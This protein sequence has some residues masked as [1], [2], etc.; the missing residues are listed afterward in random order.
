[1]AEIVSFQKKV[2]TVRDL[3]ERMKPQLALALPKHLSADRMVRVVMTEVLRNPK[4][5]DCD[6]RSFAGA[7]IQSAQL[8][9]EIGVLGLAFLVP[10]RNTKADRLDCQLIPGYK[11]LLQ[12]ARRSGQIATIDPVIV[13]AKDKYRVVKGTS[14]KIEHI[15]W[16]KDDPGEAVA[17]YAIGH[18]KAGG[19]QF[20]AMWKRE[21]EEHAKRY[22]RAYGEGPW[23]TDFDAMGLKTVLRKLTKFLPMSIELQTAVALDESA[24]AG[25][26]QDLGAIVDTTSLPQPATAQ[27]PAAPTTP[28]QPS[29]LDQLVAETKAK[30]QQESKRSEQKSADPVF[31]SQPIQRGDAPAPVHPGQ[32][33]PAETP[34]APVKAMSPGAAPVSAHDPAPPGMVRCGVASCWQYVADLEAHRREKHTRGRPPKVTPVSPAPAPVETVVTRPTFGVE[35][36]AT[37]PP[38]SGTPEP[39]APAPPSLEWSLSAIELAEDEATLD[40]VVSVIYSPQGPWK[41]ATVEERKALR[42]AIQVR[43][44]EFEPVPAA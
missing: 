33:L 12:L 42:T 20:E 7:V 38:P 25:L 37:A 31:G 36:E 9:L 5:M 44:R 3:L 29:K 2:E 43:M 17:Y 21:V 19:F 32:L 14:P 40:E 35:E 23:Q 10:F 4:L 26:P 11:G 22:S 27:G 24:E 6:P 13:R 8:G 1:M 28:A 15:P 18:F 34:P 41:E 30:D 39:P 16:E